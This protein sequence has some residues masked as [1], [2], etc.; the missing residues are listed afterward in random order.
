MKI[1]QLEKRMDNI[2]EKLDVIANNHLSH[3][4]KYTKW[5][6]VGVLCSVVVSVGAVVAT[7][8]GI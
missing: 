5:T 6:L 4:E 2:E 3:I 8:G 7:I 1:E